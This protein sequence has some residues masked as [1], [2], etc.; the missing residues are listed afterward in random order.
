MQ[1]NNNKIN[2]N[3]INSNKFLN[4]INNSNNKVNKRLAKKKG[5]VPT[6]ACKL[7]LK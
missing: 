4:N 3:K 6:K 5:K 7:K 1:V 2:N